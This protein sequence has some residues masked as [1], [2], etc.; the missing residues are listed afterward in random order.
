MGLC[1]TE[2]W[3]IGLSVTEVWPTSVRATEVWQ[4]KII[5][6]IMQI[7]RIYW[8]VATYR[9]RVEDETTPPRC[10]M[11]ESIELYAQMS[12]ASKTRTC[13]MPEPI[14]LLAQIDAT[15]GQD[16]LEDASLEKPKMQ[17]LKTLFCQNK[18]GK[19]RVWEVHGTYTPICEHVTRSLA[20]ALWELSFARQKSD[21]AHRRV[22]TR[23]QQQRTVLAG[24]HLVKHILSFWC[25]LC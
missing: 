11:P 20:T 23:A 4:T 3:Q 24:H 17:E 22:G 9:S 15:R 7:V 16:P 19:H 1:V 25:T 2:V 10:I 21:P 12:H 13:Q 8:A 5:D 18:L 14:E 6:P